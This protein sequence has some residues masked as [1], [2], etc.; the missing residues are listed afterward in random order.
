MSSSSVTA[1]L[2]KPC[3]WATMRVRCRQ[4]EDR[5]HGQGDDLGDDEPS[6]R[7]PEDVAPADE[8]HRRVGDAGDGDHRDGP[9]RERRV[10]RDRVGEP[11]AAAQRHPAER[12]QPTDPEA[13]ADDVEEQARRR[14]VVRPGR[15]RSGRSGTRAAARP[16]PRRARAPA[17]G[18]RS[19]IGRPRR[20]S[21]ATSAC[22]RSARPSDVSNASDVNKREREAGQRTGEHVADRE[23]EHHQARDR[24]DDRPAR[25]Q[26]DRG[27]GQALDHV[28]ARRQQEHRGEQEPGDD[29][30][31]ELGSGRRQRAAPSPRAGP[32]RGCRPG[33]ARCAAADLEGHDHDHQPGGEAGQDETVPNASLRAPS[34]QRGQDQRRSPARRRPAPRRGCVPLCRST[35]GSELDAGTCASCCSTV[36]PEVVVNVKV[37]VTG[38]PSSETTR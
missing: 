38:W 28:L 25:R 33:S 21:A 7:R 22:T 3:P 14:E 32:G 35:N 17:A 34:D 20:R 2:R 30:G 12:G 1:S 10:P 9:E 8:P 29:D 26:R 37:P 15:R 24:P 5:E 31:G 27:D 36:R 23:H 4:P 11:L 18:R 13:D 16:G 6:V 19:S